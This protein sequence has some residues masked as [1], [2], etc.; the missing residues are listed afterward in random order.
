MALLNLVVLVAGV[1]TLAWWRR[2]Q[3][4]PIPSHIE[5]MITD[6]FFEAAGDV[7]YVPRA[8][9]QVTAR[10]VTSTGDVV[11]DVKYSVGPDHFRITPA[12]APDPAACVA[13]FG[14]SFAFGEGINDNETFGSQLVQ[15]SNGSIATQIFGIGGW[16]PHQFL[17]GFESGRFPRAF[18]CQP[19][20]A[21]Y[22][23]I[24]GHMRRLTGRDTWARGPRFRLVNGRVEHNG[25]LP[26]QPALDDLDE[27]MLGWR[28]L[29]GVHRTGTT[30]DVEL[31]AAIF[32]DALG[33]LHALP[34]QPRLHILYSDTY[35]DPRIA[36]LFGRLAAQGV[37]VHRIETILPDFAD[38]HLRYEI[39][40]A[41]GHLNA[42]ANRLIAKY[43]ADQMVDRRLKSA[44]AS[45]R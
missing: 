36:D 21:I 1:M 23:M 42:M 9:Q 45:Q 37:I 16:G 32:R 12:S 41:D 28:R 4:R 40:P 27:G 7:G 44:A 34:T 15:G 25:N 6:G 20:V 13:V 39:G 30:D 11:Y 2:E 35:V 3:A 14:D 43:I 33:Y 38:N 17:A 5:G 29:I 8:N 24:A 31:T 10:R 18:H 22:T 26:P 19:T